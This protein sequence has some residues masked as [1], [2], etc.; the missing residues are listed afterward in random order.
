MG[1]REDD[2][3][4]DPHGDQRLSPSEVRVLKQIAQTG[5]VARNLIAFTLGAIS[6]VSGV[7]ALWEQFGKR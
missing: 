2:D 1:T 5:L 7:W 3:V 6:I 4:Y